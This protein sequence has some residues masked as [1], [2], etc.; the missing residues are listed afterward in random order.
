MWLGGCG[1]GGCCRKCW[2][3]SGRGSHHG[4][5]DVFPSLFFLSM[6]IY[7]NEWKWKHGNSMEMSGNE[8]GGEVEAK[9]PKWSPCTEHGP[10]NE[11]K[12]QVKKKLQRKS[13]SV[14]DGQTVPRPSMMPP[15]RPTRPLTGLCRHPLSYCA[16]LST[17]SSSH[18]LN[19]AQPNLPCLCLLLPPTHPSHPTPTTH[20]RIN[21]TTSHAHHGGEARRRH[22]HAPGLAGPGQATGRRRHGYVRRSSEQQD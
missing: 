8:V 19:P 6:E 4:A 12:N 11:I 17:A 21:N 7:G 9:K 18:R 14:S 16:L 3:D 20:R 1:G 13:A 15:T 2:V 5:S 10:K 22:R